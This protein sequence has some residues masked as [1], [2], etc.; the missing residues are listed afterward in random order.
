MEIINR[1]ASHDYFIKST[2]EA[3]IELK[4]TEIKSIRAGSA[5][6]S[7]SY[8]RIKNFEVYLTN[9]YIAK[10]EEG[11]RFNHDERRERK[12]LLHKKEII[13]LEHIITT[14]RYT[15][16]PLKLYFKKNKV[17]IELGVCQGKKLYD[18]RESL[19]EK[20]LRR[21]EMINY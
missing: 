12:L 4:G 11:N 15:L 13:K 14:E 2:I 6:I 16:I 20:D 10:Y 5:N 1:K 8:A 3:G 17:K 18:K 21:R 9:M 19:K 7:D